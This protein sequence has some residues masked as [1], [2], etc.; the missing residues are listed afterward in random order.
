MEKPV[1]AKAKYYP[2]I[3]EPNRPLLNRLID[4]FCL[5]KRIEFPI[6]TLPPHLLKCISQ[7]QHNMHLEHASMVLSHLPGTELLYA[8]G[9]LLVLDIMLI[10]ACTVY[11]F[12]NHIG[13]LNSA[14]ICYTIELALSLTF[15]LRKAHEL[16][17]LDMGLQLIRNELVHNWNEHGVHYEIIDTMKWS[18]VRKIVITVTAD[19]AKVEDTQE[20][21]EVI[22]T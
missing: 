10:S 17:Q 9:G 5:P 8:C 13:M 21:I 12:V 19:V 6:E 20:V 16:K 4:S 11:S 7:T 3:N 1:R 22:I 2:R 18:G 14:L 15:A